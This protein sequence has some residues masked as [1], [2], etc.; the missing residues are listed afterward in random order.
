MQV[1]DCHHKHKQ[2]DDSWRDR[3]QCIHDE[4]RQR[5]KEVACEVEGK[6]NGRSNGREGGE[7]GVGEVRKPKGGSWRAII[8]VRER[9]SEARIESGEDKGG[10]ST[11]LERR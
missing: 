3:R 9:S 4:E 11:T 2:A 1:V 10:T 6:D 7:H 5:E 8:I